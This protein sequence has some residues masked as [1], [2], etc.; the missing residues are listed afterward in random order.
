MTILEFANHP[1][2]GE[3]RVLHGIYSNIYQPSSRLDLLL[4]LGTSSQWRSSRDHIRKVVRDMLLL[5][6]LVFE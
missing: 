5:N 3:P 2:S 6:T 4:L 1:N